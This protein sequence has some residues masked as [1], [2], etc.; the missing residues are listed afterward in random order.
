MKNFKRVSR[1]MTDAR[2]KKYAKRKQLIMENGK[3]DIIWCMGLRI[4]EDYKIT[5]STVRYLKVVYLDSNNN[6]LEGRER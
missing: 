2:I 5:S 6:D 1:L 4:S 3:H